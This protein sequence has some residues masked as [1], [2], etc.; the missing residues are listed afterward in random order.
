MRAIMALHLIQP[1]TFSI[2]TLYFP[3][4]F[5]SYLFSLL[6][7][8]TSSHAPSFWLVIRKSSLVHEFSRFT[9]HPRTMQSISLAF[10]FVSHCRSF[11]SYLH[12][13]PNRNART[14][15]CMRTDLVLPWVRVKSVCWK[16]PSDESFKQTVKS[17]STVGVKQEEKIDYPL[18][19]SSSASGSAGV[20]EKGCYTLACVEASYVPHS[21]PIFEESG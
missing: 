18:A 7:F 2:H 4:L 20:R 19:G 12:V 11:L 14:H 21:K 8:S 9:K 16:I 5:F 13:Y 1:E 10:N 15:P 6:S 17:P 3:H